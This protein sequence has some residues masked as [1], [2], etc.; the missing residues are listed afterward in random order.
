MPLP[1][2][3]RKL[4]FTLIELLV[5]IAIIA[6][7]AAILFPVFLRAKD[8]ARTTECL[9]RLKDLGIAY[10]LYTE[11]WNGS[12]P[13]G[14]NGPQNGLIRWPIIEQLRGYLKTS[15][16]HFGYIEAGADARKG[17]TRIPEVFFC[18]SFREHWRKAH[19]WYMDAGTYC[20]VA[21][22]S[23]ADNQ[24]PAK[25]VSYCVSL[26]DQWVSQQHTNTRVEKPKRGASGAQ[27]AYCIFGDQYRAAEVSFPHQG[28]ANVLYLDWH[29]KWYRPESA[30]NE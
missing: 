10:A 16:T 1:G 13:S 19:G 17:D 7:L 14:V 6:I 28:G 26:W 22:D 5:V 9:S 25:K 4:G 8:Q 24:F 11:N 18:P 15:K 21:C 27:L 3:S 30:R 20:L 23:I 2:N 29:V 12:M